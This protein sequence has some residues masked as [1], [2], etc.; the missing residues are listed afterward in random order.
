MPN[1]I[2]VGQMARAYCTVEIRRKMISCVYQPFKVTRGHQK[3]MGRSINVLQQ[4]EL[5]VVGPPHYAPAP[6]KW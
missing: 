6:C 2:A 1:L 4:A 3:Y 5:P